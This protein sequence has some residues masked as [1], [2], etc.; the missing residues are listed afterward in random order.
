MN[1]K[2]SD[3]VKDKKN[4]FVLQSKGANIV[5]DFCTVLFFFFFLDHCGEVP[6]DL[7]YTQKK[8]CWVLFEYCLNALF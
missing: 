7:S 2:S 1:I 5:F 8:H 4:I 6:L 3:I